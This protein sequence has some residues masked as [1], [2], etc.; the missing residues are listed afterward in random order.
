MTKAL[1]CALLLSACG[2]DP[3]PPTPP[4]PPPPF[5]EADHGPVPQ[6]VSLGGPVL[7][8][9]KIQPIFWAN[10]AERDHVE[11]FANQL[12][13]SSYWT[14]TTSEYGVGAVATRC[15]RRSSRPIHRRPRTTS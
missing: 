13:G 7:T 6:L 2:S 1:L 12:V 8:A 11:D 3:A 10:D 5:A 14:A 15:A 4:P 9:P